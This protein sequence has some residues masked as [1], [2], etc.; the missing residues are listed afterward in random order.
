MFETGDTAGGGGALLGEEFVTCSAEEV[1]EPG[2]AG[3][4][5]RAATIAQCQSFAGATVSPKFA[6]NT[7]VE[8]GVP[9][10]FR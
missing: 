3:G 9:I 7:A 10:P 5:P 2:L 6:L 8:S 1:G 4:I